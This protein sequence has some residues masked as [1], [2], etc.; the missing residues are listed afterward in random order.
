MKPKIL[1]V[2]DEP[3]ILD[4]LRLSLRPLRAKWDMTF[5]LGGREALAV[6]ERERHDVVVSDMRMP[7]LDGAQLLAEVQRRH[8]DVVRIILSG[9]SDEQSVL[10]TVKLAHQYLSKP[11]RPVDLIQAVDRALGL[12][13][14]LEPGALKSV[15]ASL[16]SL[17]AVPSL[18]GRLVEILQDENT[19][20]KEVGDIVSQDVAMCASI[21]RLV[22][23]AFFG[24]PTRVSSIH[25][26]VNLLGGQTIRAL[27][28]GVNLFES[29]DAQRMPDFSVHG[30][31]EHSLRTACF[32]K[33]LAACEGAGNEL[34]D[35]AFIAGV[36]HDM[37]KLP[38]ACGLPG[39]YARALDLVRSEGLAVHEAERAVFGATHAE[40]GAYLMGLWGFDRG[41]I[42]AV[43]RHHDAAGL[44]QG[45]MSPALAVYA[46]NALDHELVVL[47]QDYARKPL[48]DAQAHPGFERERI[49]RWREAC[50][51][52]LEQGCAP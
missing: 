30:L 5:A 52:H 14:V 9:Y 47:H 4:S 22:N 45:A 1:F 46:A 24:L 51:A 6:L 40:A 8:P 33:A 17:P 2:D 32:A 13:G 3:N 41:Q 29:M 48:D 36:V 38:M 49:A 21:L 35:E 31:W 27:V 39:E 12:S 43:L 11:C 42:K 50:R 23:S 25:H 26:A 20:L 34:G 28:L 7:G 19:T 18:Y 44:D 16:T 15:V 10:K 37:G